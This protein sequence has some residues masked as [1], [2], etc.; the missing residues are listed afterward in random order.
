MLK[1][2]TKKEKKHQTEISLLDLIYEFEDEQALIKNDKLSGHRN[3]DQLSVLG[4][5]P[6]L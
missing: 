6:K 4:L 2:S 3:F 1:C 5:S